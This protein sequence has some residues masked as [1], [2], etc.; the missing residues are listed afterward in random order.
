MFIYTLLSF[1][2]IGSGCL[3]LA[4]HL[5]YCLIAISAKQAADKM[6][7]TSLCVCLVYA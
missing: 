2:Y 7:I 6:I 1:L 5:H 3:F 4:Q